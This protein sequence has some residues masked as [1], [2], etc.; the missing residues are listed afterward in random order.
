MSWEIEDPKETS[1]FSKVGLRV[2]RTHFFPGTLLQD[3][4]ERTLLSLEPEAIGGSKG[5]P[6]WVKATRPGQP[7]EAGVFRIP[8][9]L[10]SQGS[11]DGLVPWGVS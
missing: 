6:G 1:N 4:A 11:K 7:R 9:R 10:S 3:P 2:V 8:M 5:W